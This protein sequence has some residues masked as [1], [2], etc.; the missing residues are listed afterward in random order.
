MLAVR[1][2]GADDAVIV[3][4]HGLHPDVVA[5]YARFPL[6]APGPA[7]ACLRTGEPQWAE[8]RA[9]LLARYPDAAAVWDALG[10]E[11]VATVPLAVAGPD[12]T[13]LVVGAMS[14]GWTAPR[15]LGADDR[16]FFLTLGRQA[17]QAVE[18]TRLLAAEQA[19]RAAAE[20]LAAFFGAVLTTAPVGIA[21]YDRWLRYAH[22]NDVLA[23]SNRVPAAAHLGRTVAEVRPDLAPA[24]QPL[25]TR[26]LET[27]AAILDLPVSDHD[28]SAAPDAPARRWR[29]SLYPVRGA[30]RARRGS[31]A[32]AGDE[33]AV[34]HATD[35]AESD[36]AGPVLGVG[37]VAED[38]TER[39]RLLAESE[40]ARRAAEE[41]R[42]VAEAANR[43]KGEFLA[44]MS[45]ELRTPLNAIAGYAEL[46]AL[47]VRGPLTEA[48]SQDMARIRRANQHLTG[49][50]TD[51]LNFARLEAGQVEYHVAEVHLGPLVADLEALVGPQLAAKRL[52][53]DHDA[54]GPDTPAQPHVV[55]AD[56]EKVR[57]VLV[58]LLS[59]AIKFTD[60]GGRI[61]LACEDDAPAGV[62]RV[63]VTDTGRGIPPERLAHVFEPFVQVDRDLT[64][65]S[66]QGVGLGLAISRDLARGMG[67]ELS[68][69]SIPGEGSTFTLTLPRA[70]GP[71]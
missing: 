60:A 33:R 66:Q 27:G 47:G 50:V 30:S 71:S 57:Q 19:A 35:G 31:G 65:T 38:V 4:Q 63:R 70:P 56:A 25:L 61:S 18:R 20:E 5:R 3:R 51:V 1:P 17:A 41:A 44:T 6:T 62:V 14:Y 40:A 45:H 34:A 11:T 15:P 28:P 39:Q 13:P 49:L 7:A 9:E 16:A 42:A 37:V 55:R 68:A 36:G 59:N 8:S 52:A 67:G 53:Y 26:V 12:G 48:Q 2:A 23:A 21:V 10:T 54:C 32:T 58:N 22:I 64:H 46:L 69:E 24:L 43:A 29:V